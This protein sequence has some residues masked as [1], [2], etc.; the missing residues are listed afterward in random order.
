MAGPTNYPVSLK[1]VPPKA[2]PAGLETGPLSPPLGEGHPHWR[3]SQPH[4]RATVPR[5]NPTSLS[6]EPRSGDSGL[7]GSPPK[8]ESLDPWERPGGDPWQPQ[9]PERY[10]EDRRRSRFDQP[11]R[12]QPLAAVGQSVASTPTESEVVNSPTSA[13]PTSVMQSSRRHS[14]A[15][16]IASTSL[17]SPKGRRSSM[18]RTVHLVRLRLHIIRIPSI[19]PCRNLSTLGMP[20]PMRNESGSPVCAW[21]PLHSRR[22]AP[23]HT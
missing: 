2:A 5:G 4:H 23:S 6:P 10:V 20:S 17:H 1:P 11:D 21:R 19:P 16:T 7:A 12:A 3:A 22:S 8:I 14:S 9:V 15:G 18:P 13:S